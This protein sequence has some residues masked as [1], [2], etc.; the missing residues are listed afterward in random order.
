MDPAVETLPTF[1]TRSVKISRFLAGTDPFGDLLLPKRSLRR[2]DNE[3]TIG[4]WHIAGNPG[5]SAW[6][7]THELR[8]VEPASVEKAWP[9]DALVIGAGQAGIAVG[10]ELL[11]RGYSG[12]I[13]IRHDDGLPGL[14]VEQPTFV[15]LDAESEPG[16]AWRHQSYGITVGELEELKNLPGYKLNRSGR[17]AR[18]AGLVHGEEVG[19]LFTNERARDVFPRYFTEYE[20]KFDLPVIRPVRV[21]RVDPLPGD[22]E[23]RLLVQTSMGAWITKR[24]YN[25]TGWWTRP[26][27][28]MIPGLLDFRGSIL[29]TKDYR[30]ALG[31]RGQSVAVIGESRSAGRHL[32]ELA[33][34]VEKLFWCTNSQSAEAI[35]SQMTDCSDSQNLREAEIAV[36][37]NATDTEMPPP[38]SV[39]RKAYPVIVRP[40]SLI[41]ADGTEEKVDSLLFST[42]FRPELRHL[43][44]IGLRD[45]RGKVALAGAGETECVKDSRVH[46]IGA[47]P[48]S[49][50]A[51][52]RKQ[53]ALAV[54]ESL[55]LPHIKNHAI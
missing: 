19:A 10:W 12:Y 26:F 36:E 47:D 44:P 30:T 5:N 54:A 42:G 38:P 21:L 1:P 23:Q 29:H 39:V 3:D 33:P 4:M 55:A 49:N 31:A 15:I 51:S 27:I 46:I 48:N 25:C 35:V 45:E 40:R 41:W 43:A 50:F 13:G 17:R 7:Q 32:A 53:A 18:K 16:G 14:E 24:I 52:T 37:I 34:V 2:Q 9:V 22:H 20:D 28:P 6:K 8:K 11:Q